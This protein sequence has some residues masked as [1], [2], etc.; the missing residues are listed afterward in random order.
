MMVSVP[1]LRR[2]TH[3]DEVEGLAE[4][5]PE[6]LSVTTK[7]VRFAILGYG[8]HA[9]YRLLPAFLKSEQAQLHGFWRRD[10]AKAAATAAAT[11]LRAFASEAELCA[12]PDIDAVFITSPD[13][14][15]VL[16]AELAFAHGKAVLC[17]KPLAMSTAEADQMLTAS[18]KAGAEFG[19]A[20]NFRFNTSI[21]YIRD[22]IAAGDIGIPRTAHTEFN[23]PAQNSKRTWITDPKLAAGGPI[24][25]VGV[26]C[27]DTLRYVLGADVRSIATIATQDDFSGEV[28]ASAAL[29]LELT[30]GVL[31]SVS[32]SAR[33]LYRT[34]LEVVGSEGALIAENAMTVDFPVDVSL[35]RRGMHVETRTFHN[36]DAYTRMIDNFARAV[37]GEEAFLCTGEDG[38]QN[39]RCLDAAYRGWKSGRREP[40]GA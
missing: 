40:V 17:E 22:R 39:Q 1:P 11:G 35:R 26:H 13:A 18:R 31:A 2:D 5:P 34:M 25:D 10:A 29:Q 21:E 23:Y 30:S 12:S 4:T 7:P 27:I 33:A 6:E 38:V 37:K 32:V 28:E 14:A 3:D 8:H 9:E 24:G 15:H 20:H 16:D 19:V 36:G